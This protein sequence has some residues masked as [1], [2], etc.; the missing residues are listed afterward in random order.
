MK[1][2]DKH[3]KMPYFMQKSRD[4]FK[5]HMPIITYFVLK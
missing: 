5:K 2:K 4:Y 1:S 3:V